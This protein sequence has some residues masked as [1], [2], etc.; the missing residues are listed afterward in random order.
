MSTNIYIESGIIKT[1]I[2][3]RSYKDIPV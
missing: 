3:K 1:H 2:Y